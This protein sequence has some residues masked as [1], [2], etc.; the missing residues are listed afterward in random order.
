M[1]K[2]FSTFL[3]EMRDFKEA[4]DP[5]AINQLLKSSM[6]E[7]DKEKALKS[8]FDRQDEN[9]QKRIRNQ[10]KGTIFSN[11]FKKPVFTEGESMSGKKTNL[12][13]FLEGVESVDVNKK[14]KFH[15]V[16]RL[17]EEKDLG[18]DEDI[19]RKN[20][21]LAQKEVD[22][23]SEEDEEDMDEARKHETEEPEDEENPEHES[24]ESDDEEEDERECGDDGEDEDEDEMDENV[25]DDEEESD[26]EEELDEDSGER[27]LQVLGTDIVEP[28]EIF[29]GIMSLVNGVFS[30]SKDKATAQAEIAK[31]LEQLKRESSNRQAERKAKADQQ[32]KTSVKDMALK[33]NVP[34]ASKLEE[35]DETEEM[36][37]SAQGYASGLKGVRKDAG[38]KKLKSGKNKVPPAK[39]NIT[40]DKKLLKKPVAMK[41]ESYPKSGVAGAARPGAPKIKK[42]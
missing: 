10:L 37:E 35:N 31:K 18:D 21:E 16:Y 15:S 28:K 23:E 22:E 42:S 27:R 12:D 19:E 20:Q 14:P 5:N 38:A 32:R 25:G 29:N 1:S 39:V 34:G 41:G 24:E 13:L 3:N 8:Y 9:N 2:E 40:G 36:D 17:Y 4:F 33:K 7:A 11:L 30:K 26:D 6:S